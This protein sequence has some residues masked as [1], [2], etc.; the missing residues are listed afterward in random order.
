MKPPYD[1]GFYLPVRLLLYLLTN[2]CLLHF[3]KTFSTSMGEPI[4][5]GLSH[6][7]L[8]PHPSVMGNVVCASSCT[9]ES[10]TQPVGTNNFRHIVGDGGLDFLLSYFYLNL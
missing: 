8:T 2:L 9:S 4:Q 7:V 1:S 6:S 10:A 3:P 5:T